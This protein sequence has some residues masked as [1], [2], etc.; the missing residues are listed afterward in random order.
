MKKNLKDKLTNVCG[1][2]VLIAGSILALPTAG[3]SLPVSVITASTF[4][5]TVAGSVV[6]WLTGKGQDGKPKQL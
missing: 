3:V 1:L 6:A 2:V 4:S 5:L